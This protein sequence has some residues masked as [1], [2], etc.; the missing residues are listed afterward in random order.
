ML[1][2]CHGYDALGYSAPGIVP[3]F[4]GDWPTKHMK[5]VRSYDYFYCLINPFV[6]VEEEKQFRFCS[7]LPDMNQLTQFCVEQTQIT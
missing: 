4:R 3:E 2:L 6:A 5:S 1:I 7:G